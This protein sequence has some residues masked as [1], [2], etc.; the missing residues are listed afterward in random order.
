MKQ[1]LVELQRETAESTI[2]LRDFNAPLSEV[3]RSSRQK[4]IKNIVEGFPGGTVVGNPPA[5]AG[6][7]GSSPVPG[8]SHMPWSN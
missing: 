4:I 3:N 6:D 2:I 8:T 1:K 7:T 5:N